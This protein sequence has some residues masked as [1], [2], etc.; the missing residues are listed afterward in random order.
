MFTIATFYRFVE[1]ENYEDMQLP[2]KQFCV[3][4]SIKGTVLLA[5]EGINATIAGTNQAIED[6]FTFMNSDYRLADIKWQESRASYQPF[7]RMKVRLKLEII[8]LGVD[9]LDMSDRGQYLSPEEWDKLMLDKDVV[10]VDTR[11]TYEIKLGKFKSAVSPDTL[12]FRDF[13][14][15]AQTLPKDKKVAMYCT[16]GIRC[17]KSTAYMKTLGFKDVYHLQGG[18][19]N[20]LATTNNKQDNW[21]GECFVF[22]DRVAI[23]QDLTPSDQIK[24]VMCGEKASTDDL[25]SVP[26]GR[27]KCQD[28]I[29]G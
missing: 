26:K 6:F 22:D 16:G 24:C 19:I 10:V 29:D 3:E 15:W 14:S 21:Q 18:I 12:N 20:Y 13:P 23:N 9:N 5:E 25:K 7:D 11:N 4:R 8:R 28:C 1:L 17:E 27:V 2:I